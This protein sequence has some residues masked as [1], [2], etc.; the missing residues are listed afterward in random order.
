MTA[1]P[2]P[3]DAGSAGPPVTCSL[4]RAGLAGQ[5]ARWARLTAR[6]LAGQTKT[7]HGFRLRFRP[8]PGAEQ[9]LRALAAVETECCPWATWTVQAG[10]ARLVLDVRSAG[11]G[12]AALHGMLTSLRQVPVPR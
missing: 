3:A 11:D 7:A 9:E 4:T 10:P 1:P 8:E 2:I 5:A 6:A 12:V